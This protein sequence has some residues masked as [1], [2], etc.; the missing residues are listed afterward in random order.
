M[1]GTRDRILVLVEGGG[2]LRVSADLVV[3]SN[4]VVVGIARTLVG[5]QIT[6]E[7]RWPVQ[8]TREAVNRLEIRAAVLARS[9]QTPEGV[10]LA[11]V[12]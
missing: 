8:L 7:V 11:G 2:S 6:R 12:D 5:V 1:L 4:V 9:V 10:E 3:G